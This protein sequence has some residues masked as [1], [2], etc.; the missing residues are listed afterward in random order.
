[1]YEVKQVKKK[2]DRYP[3]GSVLGARRTMRDTLV[4][5]VTLAA[6][7]E[8]IVA[9][10]AWYQITKDTIKLHNFK[11]LKV[12]EENAYGLE[13]LNTLYRMVMEVFFEKMETIDGK[14]IRGFY[15]ILTQMQKQHHL[16]SLILVKQ[17]KGHV[18]NFSS[19][20]Q[21]KTLG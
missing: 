8:F 13:G 9:S 21:R 20:P 10:E 17:M 1:M 6:I 4:T 18:L 11:L 7:M 5:S 16:C 12:Y 15:S 3:L 14:A 19:F 2:R